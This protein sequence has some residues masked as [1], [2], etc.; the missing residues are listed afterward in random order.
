L[1]ER[2]EEVRRRKKKSIEPAV[3]EERERI[4]RQRAR[5]T[6]KATER[7]RERERERARKT[8]QYGTEDCVG[9][10]KDQDNDIRPAE[11][12]TRLA[13]VT[14][15]GVVAQICR[16]HLKEKERKEEEE[17]EGR[18]EGKERKA[19]RNSWRNTRAKK[20]TKEMITKVENIL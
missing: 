3:K 12:T 18:E 16:I 6:K 7:E 14:V 13:A 15:N 19:I 10:E 5:G 2:W 20:K 11:K 4:S 9:Q 8:N 17:G 1:R